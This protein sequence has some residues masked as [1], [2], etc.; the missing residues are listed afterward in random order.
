MFSQEEFSDVRV[1]CPNMVATLRKRA[2]GEDA[3][4]NSPTFHWMTVHEDEPVYNFAFNIDDSAEIA[5]Y[6][7]PPQVTF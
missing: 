4:V 3:G 7:S 1:T 6:A 5:K 2:S